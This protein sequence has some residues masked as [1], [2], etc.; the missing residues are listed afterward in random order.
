MDIEP[1]TGHAWI[2]VGDFVEQ[3]LAA[4]GN[5]DLV[6]A[7]VERFGQ[8]A[9]NTAGGARNQNGVTANVQNNVLSGCSRWKGDDSG[10]LTGD[11]R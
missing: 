7:R 10:Y 8:R 5:N 11:L 1:E 2:G 4:P 9:A 6:A 3:S